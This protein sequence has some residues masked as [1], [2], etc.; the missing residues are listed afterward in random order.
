[1]HSLAS[2]SLCCNRPLLT[3]DNWVD[4]FRLKDRETF[5][6]LDAAPCVR[7]IWSGHTHLHRAWHYRDKK[8]VIFPSLDFGIPG[9]C[10]WGVG[11]FGR[12]QLEALF[13][14]PVVG[15]WFDCVSEGTLQSE[16]QLESLSFENYTKDKRFNPC[17]LPR[18]TTH[19]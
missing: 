16:G 9:P 15:P 10:G 11:G 5:D 4:D 1:M 13:I 14:K 18:E 6:L 17:L 8:H 7:T 12:D 2:R 3:V 19:S